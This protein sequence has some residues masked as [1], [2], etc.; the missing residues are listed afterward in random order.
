M[1][2]K[3][4]EVKERLYQIIRTA[5]YEEELCNSDGDVI[6]TLYR[7]VV[8]G[9][10]AMLLVDKLVENGVTFKDMQNNTSIGG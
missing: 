9:G 7:P 1:D 4:V 10:L 5:K 3:D 6:T 8:D 2:D